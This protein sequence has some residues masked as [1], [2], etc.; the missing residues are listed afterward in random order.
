[1]D[2][3]FQELYAAIR[4]LAPLFYAGAIFDRPWDVSPPAQ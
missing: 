3:N 1:M 4:E 2:R